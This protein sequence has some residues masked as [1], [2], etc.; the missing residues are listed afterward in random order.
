MTEKSMYWKEVDVKQP[1]SIKR[2]DSTEEDQML[3]KPSWKQRNV[4]SED[5]E[6]F[7]EFNSKTDDAWLDDSNTDL[8]FSIDPRETAGTGLSKLH[9]SLLP[10]DLQ[11]SKRTQGES[12][13]GSSGSRNNRPHLLPRQLNSVSPQYATSDIYIPPRPAA[14]TGVS[15]PA[16]STMEPVQEVRHGTVGPTPHSPLDGYDHLTKEDKRVIKFDSIFRSECPD[17]ESIRKMSWFG[18]PRPHRPIVWQMLSGY[19]PPNESR[20]ADTLSRKRSEYWR[21]VAQYFKTRKDADFSSLYH[22]IHIDIPRTNPAIKLFQQQKVQEAFERVLYI[23]AYRNPGSG[24]VQGINDLVT[25]FYVVFLGQYVEGDVEKAD[26]SQLTDET[27]ANTE[28]DTYWCLTKLLDNLHDNYTFAQPGIQMKVHDLKRLVNRMD[29][30]LDSHLERNVVEYLQFSFRWMN[31]LLMREMP[32]RCIIRLWDTYLSEPNGFSHF[33][34][35]VCAKFMTKWTKVIKSLPDFQ[36]IML[37]VQSLPTSK[38]TDDDIAE[39]VSEAFQ[40]KCLFPKAV[41]AVAGTT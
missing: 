20:R 2:V 12:S 31:N 29:S 37:F 16:S 24:Y 35:Y 13:G 36:A 14:S 6:K 3:K 8:E 38:W 4:S 1:G 10:R 11:R 33:H 30:D 32:L 28:A 5:E 15:P 7:A 41:T 17:L 40:L 34:L 23:W 21:F 18:C 25:P 27:L 9:P 19:L 26:I 22:Q 39:L